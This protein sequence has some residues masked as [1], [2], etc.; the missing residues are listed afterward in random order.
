MRNPNP[1]M[2]DMN[3]AVLNNPKI[4]FKMHP[5]RTLSSLLNYKFRDS[6]LQQL[7]GRYSTYVGGS[8]L[9]SPALLSLIWQ[10]EARGVW[11]IKGGMKKL[12]RVLEKLAKDRGASFHYSTEVKELNIK[13]DRLVSVTD[14]LN[15]SHEAD[16]FIFNGDPRALALGKLG[17]EVKKVAPN[18]ADC[19]RSLSAYVWGFDAKV[20]GPDLVHHNVFFS[21]VKNSEFYDI[22]KGKMPVDP[23]IY[24]CA[25]DRGKNAPYPT[26]ERFEIILNAPPVSRRKSTPEDYEKCKEITFKRLEMFGLNFQLNLKRE[27][28]TTPQDFEE[29]FPASD[30]SLYGR[31]PHS[32][33]ATL[34]RPKCV[35]SLQNLFLVGGG[36][37]PGAG[38]PMATLCAQLAVEEMTKDQT[39][40]LTFPQMATH[41]GTLTE[42]TR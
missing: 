12:A 11:S 23:S 1:S 22:K 3:R 38:V 41:G 25:Q 7:F 19:E 18:E 17:Q 13:Y 29:L 20:S 36:V 37:H 34:K 33:L 9:E 40:I 39:S 31:S 26:T 4:L 15:K 42:S 28:L 5:L 14:N 16:K 10:A 32:L 24:I 35:T 2:L 27:N 21:D 30:G 6:R 8:P